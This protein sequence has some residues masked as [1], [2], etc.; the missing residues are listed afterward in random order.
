M[1]QLQVAVA[2]L[3]K[4]RSSRRSRELR[5]LGS[6]TNK[7]VFFGSFHVR[8]FPFL[9]PLA[10]FWV[11]NPRVARI[12]RAECRVG[13][14]SPAIPSE[15]RERGE[16]WAAAG[17]ILPLSLA[18]AL[19]QRMGGRSWTWDSER[20]S[21]TFPKTAAKPRFLEKWCDDDPSRTDTTNVAASMIN[22]WVAKRPKG[23]SL[24]RGVWSVRETRILPSFRRSFSC[25][26]RFWSFLDAFFVFPALTTYVLLSM[27]YLLSMIT[28]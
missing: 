16:I 8:S 3:Q 28:Y 4:Q 27:Y 25:F 6:K 24:K 21:T 17:C 14:I 5:L 20:R 19:S 7:I 22:L 15:A 9:P 23:W 18:T 1:I 13:Q 11:A 26:L 10:A 12:W 2:F